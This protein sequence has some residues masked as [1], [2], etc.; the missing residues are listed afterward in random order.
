MPRLFDRIYQ[1]GAT[2]TLAGPAHARQP[3][4][5]GRRELSVGGIEFWSESSRWPDVIG[6]ELTFDPADLYCSALT[7][8]LRA[9]RCLC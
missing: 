1:A 8:A 9:E 5:A 3:T 2:F 7:L 4:H 6:H